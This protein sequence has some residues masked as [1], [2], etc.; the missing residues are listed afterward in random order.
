MSCLAW[1]SGCLAFLSASLAA[2][3]APPKADPVAEGF[4]SWEGVTSRNYIH[5]RMI[6]P[7]DLRHRVVMLVSV[8]DD[9]NLQKTLADIGGLVSSMDGVPA[10]H[11]AQWDT[12]E[13]V[14][15]KCV[16]VI[17]FVDPPKT[18][19]DDLKAALKPSKSM[20]EDEA[21]T[22]AQ[23]WSSIAPAFYRDISLCGA[24]A[25]T[26]FPYVTVMDGKSAEP[27]FKGA[28]KPADAKKIRAI[29]NKA[30]SALPAWREL[31]GVEE[32]VH[33]KNVEK[34]IL[35]QKPLKQC[36]STLRAGLADK[37]PEKAREA[38]IMYDALHQFCSDLKL[39]ISLEFKASPAR[40]FADAQRLFKYF[41]AEKKS[42]GSVDAY[43]KANKSAVTLGKMYEKYLEWSQPDF[44]FK[45]ASDAK[46]AV[47]LVNSWKKPL[48]KMSQD[49]SNAVLQGEA[50]LILSQIEMLGDILMTKVPQ[51]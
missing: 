44:T 48:E 22:F 31:T 3:A 9:D 35:A 17:S 30:K 51:K 19:A 14:P 10:G 47:Q 34:I 5:G 32:V 13:S 28:Y 23:V 43:L 24:E 46:K 36:F 7:S 20:K 1:A 41:P 11:L 8:K 33:Y 42:I 15:R 25:P 2:F 45:N 12:M 38:Q 37:N 21:R 29:A 18:V 39:R 6:T 16:I 50:S 49:S 40:A 27:V 26:E 4:P